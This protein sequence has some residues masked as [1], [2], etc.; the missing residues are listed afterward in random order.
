MINSATRPLL[1]TIFHCVA[2][3]C[4]RLVQA[5][6]ET[7]DEY[8][9]MVANKKHKYRP[10]SIRDPD[11]SCAIDIGTPF[12]HQLAIINRLPPYSLRGGT[13]MVMLSL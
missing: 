3:L 5:A 8:L 9:K 11:R 13:A 10:Y 7:V 6:V 12:R 1:A 4:T 2:F